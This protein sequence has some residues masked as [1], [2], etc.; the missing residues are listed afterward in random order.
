MHY[1]Y[2]EEDGMDGETEQNYRFA[3]KGGVGSS[4]L[5]AERP[6]GRIYVITGRPNEE[7]DM[8]V[9]VAVAFEAPGLT[10]SQ[11]E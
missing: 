9:I 10:V 4:M 2:A 6:R 1:E 3:K 7:G 11:K 8:T 5:C